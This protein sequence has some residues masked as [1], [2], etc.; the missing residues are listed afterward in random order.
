[1]PISIPPRSRCSRRHRQRAGHEER[2][3]STK[4]VRV[5]APRRLR[6][7]RSTWSSVGRRQRSRQHETRPARRQ[8][9]PARRGSQAPARCRQVLRASSAVGVRRPFHQLAHHV[10][11]RAE[12]RRARGRRDVTRPRCHRIWA[13]NRGPRAARRYTLSA[14]RSERRVMT[15]LRPPPARSL[16]HGAFESATAIPARPA[17]AAGVARRRRRRWTADHSARPTHARRC[18]RG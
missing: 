18:R 1:M 4:P 14:A 15:R 5:N 6:S 7:G 16:R 13:P 2:A 12:I 11:Q 8:H 3:W 9:L 17:S 10:G